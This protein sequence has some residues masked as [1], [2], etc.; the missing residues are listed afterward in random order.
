MHVKNSAGIISLLVVLTTA[1]VAG[2]AAVDSRARVPT[3]V[4]LQIIRAE[5]ERRWDDILKKLLGDQN[6]QVRERAALA[7]GRIGNEGAV[8]ILAEML[9]TDHDNDV[10]QMAAF[11]LGE[12]ESPGGAY[13]LLQVVRTG[14]GSDRVDAAVRARAV[15]ALGKIVAALIANAPADT[16]KPAQ[17]EDDRLDIIRAAIVDALRFENSRRSQSDRLTILLALTAV[18]RA[19]P[20]GVGKLIAKVLDYAD[21]RI[22]ADA[23]NTL[24]RLRLKDGNDE[25]RQLLVKHTDPIVRANAARVLGATEDKQA[26]D[27]LLDRALHDS[28]LRVRVSAIRA[29]GGLKDERAAQ[30]LFQQIARL[31]ES[32]RHD[33]PTL[34]RLQAAEPPSQQ[35]EWLEIFTSL[36]NILFGKK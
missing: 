2:R 25:A 35:N 29:L 12:I 13:A 7:A 24:A 32:L 1:T 16:S 20:D 3:P 33:R 14:S 17:T 36:G 30:P 9:L 11:G 5:D 26:F 27:A 28:D 21:P 10:R 19:K 15:E 31:A 23:L 4:L 6:P 34:L 18:L 22:V 8:P